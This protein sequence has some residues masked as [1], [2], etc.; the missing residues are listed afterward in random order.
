[1]HIA[2]HRCVVI[3]TMVI[4]LAA[5]RSGGAAQQTALPCSELAQ[6]L[7]GSPATSGNVCKV[8]LPRVD[9]QVT[10]LGATLPPGAGLTSWAAFLPAADGALVMGDLALTTTELSS[11]LRGLRDGGF[12]VT[13]VHRHML[14]ETP[15][16]SFAHYMGHGDARDLAHKLRLALG[17]PTPPSP[18]PG[19][20]GERGVVSGVPCGAIQKLLGAG[21]SGTDAGAGFCKITLPRSDLAVT[22][23][24]TALPPAMGVASWFA[25]QE[26]PDRSAVVLTGD[27]ALTEAQVSNALGAMVQAGV[28]VVAL[29]NHMTG[30]QPRIVFFHFQARGNAAT[31][32]Q[33]VHDA[34]QASRQERPPGKAPAARLL[35][36]RRSGNPDSRM[37]NRFQALP[38]RT[39]SRASCTKG[40]V[41]TSIRAPL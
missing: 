21:D 36:L 35:Q 40:N 2:Q 12:N 28:D 38:L 9:L 6:I 39:S 30:E 37:R 29:H 16:M 31:L 34:L 24:G 23:N 22:L 7:G 4:A 13:A 3:G 20:I 32:A 5:L 14:D 25:F 8:N 26:V 27:M 11:V 19:S 17:A 18:F 33:A 41:L 10:L 1:M 15:P